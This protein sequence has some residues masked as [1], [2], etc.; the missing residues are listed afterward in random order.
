LP[1]LPS[2]KASERLVVP[3][4]AMSMIFITNVRSRDH[5]HQFKAYIA[6]RI[7]YLL[8]LAIE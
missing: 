8:G 5:F 2:E 1:L 6:P 4:T 3:V 7:F